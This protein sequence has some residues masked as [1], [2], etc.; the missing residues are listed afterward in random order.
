MVTA[1]SRLVEKGLSQRRKV[2]FF[3]T[4]VSLL[5]VL[6]RVSPPTVDQ[7]ETWRRGVYRVARVLVGPLQKGGDP[8]SGRSTTA[9]VLIRIICLA[10]FATLQSFQKSQDNF[11]EMKDRLSLERLILCPLATE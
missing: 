2:I 10:C 1:N 5:R 8:G 9:L 4:F 6:V 3:T 11:Y 7:R